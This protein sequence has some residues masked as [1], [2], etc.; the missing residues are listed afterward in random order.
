MSNAEKYRP[1]DS[2]LK[3]MEALTQIARRAMGY[4][5]DLVAAVAIVQEASLMAVDVVRGDANDA[6]L[7]TTCGRCLRQLDGWVDVQPMR[8][9]LRTVMTDIEST[10]A[11]SGQV[12]DGFAALPATDNAVERAVEPPRKQRTG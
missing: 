3:R 6:E 8:R 10:L 4:S 2:Q 5:D 11:A 12:P 1:T 7:H 9:V